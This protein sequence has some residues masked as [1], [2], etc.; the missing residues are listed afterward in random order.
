VK[1]DGKTLGPFEADGSG[2]APGVFVTTKVDT[3]YS[4]ESVGYGQGFSSHRTLLKGKQVYS[5]V[6]DEIEFF[7][8]SAP[9]SQKDLGYVHELVTIDCASAP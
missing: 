6:A 2:V 5:I 9:S 1:A 7:L 3:C 4:L 8:R